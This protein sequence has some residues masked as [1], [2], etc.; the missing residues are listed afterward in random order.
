[1]N[2]D[3]LKA[4]PLFAGLSG[5]DLDWLAEQAQSVT[6]NAGEYLIL[7]GGPGD[8]AYIVIEGE[9]E[10]IKKSDQREIVIAVRE[11]GA[12]IGEMALIDN[13]PR[14]ASVRAVS[15]GSLLRISDKVFIQLLE[16]SAT[17]VMAILRTV[18]GRLRQND[19]MLRQSEKMAA[20]GTLS[21]G[22][23]HELN[24]PAS[25]ARRSADLLR[26]KLNDWQ[27]LN[28]ELD[29]LKL[30]EAQRNRLSTLRMDMSEVHEKK[31]ID[32]PLSQSDL[33]SDIQNWLVERGVESAWEISPEL[34]SAG[35]TATSL[36]DLCETYT[37]N[38]LNIVVKWLASGY[39][40]HA[41]IDEVRMST[42]RI[43]D[44]VKSVKEYSYLDQA[45]LQEVDVHDGLNNTLVIL[46]HKLKDGIQISKEYDSSLPR[47][48][49]YGSEL[50][51]VWTN[52]LDN[53]IDALNGKGV[54]NI[55]TF[56]IDSFIYVE[57]K[58]N[59][60]GIPEE[61]QKRIFEPFFTTKP[62]G[63]GTGLGLHISYSI[64][65]KHYGEIRVTSKPGETC[66]QVKLPKSLPKN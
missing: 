8:S 55:R 51:Q 45:P 32:D 61:I 13:T 2:R 46:R 43:S 38:Q 36:S 58:D 41:L 54:I 27:Q 34:A 30:D 16:K 31:S 21:A 49:A 22:L 15:K 19:A 7:E 50:N 10:I 14:V 4:Q 11:P 29:Q 1:M 3:F 47:I 28:S 9:F 5:P 52:I 64:I 42:E 56:S 17:A 40:V 24:N 53:A 18:S 6:I 33:E 26:A 23:A 44:I 66:F 12:V 37:P 59:G 39:T 57:I 48:E 63:V 65:H 60:P 25:A 62:P 35:F 20:L